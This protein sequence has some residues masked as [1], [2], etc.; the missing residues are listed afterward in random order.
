MWKT[1]VMADANPKKLVRYEDINVLLTMILF[2]AKGSLA[3]TISIAQK[4]MNR[5]AK[6]TREM[7]VT[8]SDQEM[9]PPLS[10]PKRRKN[11]EETKVRA[12]RKSTRLSLG[13]RSPV[14]DLGS[15]SAK[16][17]A[18]IAIT[19]SGTWRKKDLGNKLSG[20]FL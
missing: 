2:G 18:N 17:T 6:A 4:N 16:V 14:G 8:L 19:V 3:S 5:M 11:I 12:P 10:K 15:L 1:I 7:I 9:L 20:L 13:Q